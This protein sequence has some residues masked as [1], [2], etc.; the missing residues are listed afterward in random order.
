MA[1]EPSYEAFE[2]GYA[3][4]ENQIVFTRLAADLLQQ[5]RVLKDLLDKSGNLNL[6][7]FVLKR[8]RERPSVAHRVQLFL[9]APEQARIA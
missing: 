2:A 7:M 1:L 5:R 6:C 3:R 4:G 8:E 9:Q